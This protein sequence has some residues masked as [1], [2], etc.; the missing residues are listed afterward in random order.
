VFVEL[1]ITMV[2]RSHSRG[3]K[4]AIFGAHR[5]PALFRHRRDFCGSWVELE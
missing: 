4:S 1:P 3:D 2:E 5:N